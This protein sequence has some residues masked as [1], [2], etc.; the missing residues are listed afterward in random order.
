MS[1]ELMLL[2][3]NINFVAFSAFLHDLEHGVRPPSRRRS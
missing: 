2:A 3:V 1:V